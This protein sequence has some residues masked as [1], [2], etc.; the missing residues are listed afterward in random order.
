MKLYE[1]FLIE[2]REDYILKTLGPKIESWLHANTS[3]G[4]KTAN[5]FVNELAKHDPSPSK[6][7]LQWMTR[8]V[9]N[10]AT[11]WEDIGKFTEY[12]QLF[13]KVKSRL[14]KKDINGYQSARDLYNAI[15]DFDP[16][17]K[18]GK[19]ERREQRDGF[20]K[21][22]EIEEVYRDNTVQIL[23]PKTQAASVEF[24]IGTKW[25][26]A[27]TKSKNYFNQYNA[28][29]P[30]YMINFLGKTN[31]R[32]QIH[33][34]SGQFMDIHDNPVD[35]QKFKKQHPFVNTIFA[36]QIS[37]LEARASELQWTLHKFL[38]ECEEENKNPPDYMNEIED[39]V[40][41]INLMDPGNQ[42]DLVKIF[43]NIV[44][45]IQF[46]SVAIQ[47]LAIKEGSWKNLNRINLE[48]I[49]KALKNP[50]QYPISQWNIKNIIEDVPNHQ[51]DQII[52]EILIKHP[53]AFRG[54]ND[55]DKWLEFAYTHGA[56][57]HTW[58]DLSDKELWVA[59]KYSPNFIYDIGTKRNKLE[60]YDRLSQDQ[61]IQAIKNAKP[62][63]NYVVPNEILN[64]DI[65]KA[66]ITTNRLS[67]DQI[68]DYYKGDVTKLI[69]PH[70]NE[71]PRLLR[72]IPWNLMTKK[73]VHDALTSKDT[74]AANFVNLT[75]IPTKL[76]DIDM[77]ANYIKNS[78]YVA[79]S[80]ELERLSDYI[81][82]NP[83]IKDALQ[84]SLNAYKAQDNNRRNWYRT[85][86]GDWD[87][88][89]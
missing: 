53:N 31:E 45:Y 66:V 85:S 38:D 81:T 20:F 12:L 40:S 41:P 10:K 46:P 27:A 58:M 22:G 78:P 51:R 54:L 61:I 24:G 36:K 32:Y 56:N 74:K 59:A 82:S 88:R 57:L 5:E 84:V 6:I 25:C 4:I 33:F 8:T 65:I 89:D 47:S 69:E 80:R 55:S 42:H 21:R 29:G 67:D 28:D 44:E 86:S 76:I 37:W 77:L 60:L 14:E 2:S 34:E 72:F 19:Q 64:N 23:H 43:S 26:T 11:P 17:V 75:M 15:K 87:F 63:Y 13:E 50:Q 30:I 68:R 39:A 7:Y 52:K 16:T 35:W 79:I 62:S 9:L 73:Q 48:F 18:T 70:L 83:K 71:N 49:E 1:L 3:L